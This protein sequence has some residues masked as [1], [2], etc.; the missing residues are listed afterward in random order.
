MNTFLIIFKALP[1]IVAAIKVVEAAVPGNGQGKAKLDA[2]LALVTNMYADLG[3]MLPQLIGVIGTFVTL[4]NA[5]G[6]FK[7]QQV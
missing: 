7:Q 1:D 3:T 5:T 2:V 6:A 4:F